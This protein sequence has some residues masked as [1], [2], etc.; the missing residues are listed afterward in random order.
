MNNGDCLYEYHK[1]W[2]EKVV[3]RGTHAKLTKRRKTKKNAVECFYC[4]K[5]VEIFDVDAASHAR[6]VV[7]EKGAS[8]KLSVEEKRGV[9]DLLEVKESVVAKGEVGLFALSRFKKGDI[10]T[11][12]MD[13]DGLGM[14]SGFA[15]TAGLLEGCSNNAIK[16]ANGV[17]R[18][19]IRIMPGQEVLIDQEPSCFHPVMLLEAVVRKDASNVK[20]KVTSFSSS[21]VG[22][23]VYNVSFE[24]NSVSK[25]PLEELSLL[26]CKGKRR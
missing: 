13:E 22:S 10:I 16:T 2:V 8:L 20:G 15:Q 1:D 12:T 21:S 19:T 18:A 3:R 25:M 14:G 17:V 24:D 4:W 7:K 11:I 9:K 6:K 5:S 23:V 26:L